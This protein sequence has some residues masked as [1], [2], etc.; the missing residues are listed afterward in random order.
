MTVQ[1]TDSET[2][3]APT[4]TRPPRWS[5][6]ERAGAGWALLG[7][8]SSSPSFSSRTTHGLGGGRPDRE[9]GRR[10]APSPVTPLFGWSHWLVAEQI[11]T[12]VAM[13][14]IVVVFALLWRRYPK[15]PILLMAICCTS[16]VWQDPIMNWA[17]YA[18]T[19]HSSG[20][21]R[22]PGP[23]YLCRRRSSR[24]CRRLRNVLPGTVLSGHIGPRRLQRRREVDSFVWKHPLICMGLFIYLIGFIYD[25]AQEILLVRTG[26]YVYSQVIPFGSVFTGHA[27]QFP[28][29]WSCHSS[30]RNDPVACCSI[31]TTLGAPSPRSWPSGSGFVRSGVVLL[32]PPST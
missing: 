4:P 9:S 2:V 13:V 28:F 15:H 29:I 27:Y 26:M 12:I 5:K 30:R 32:L 25:A 1:L 14:L 19:T 10:G 23:W 18:V 21:G 20:T 6:G 3:T 7:C 8:A 11:G 31:G 17:P 16:I 22:R 24:S